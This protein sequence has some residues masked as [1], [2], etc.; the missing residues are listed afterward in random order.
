M[1][2]HRCRCFPF[3][4]TAEFPG[5]GFHSGARVPRYEHVFGNLLDPIELRQLGRRHIL[6]YVRLFRGVWKKLD[7]IVAVVKALVEGRA[8]VRTA[9]GLI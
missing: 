4:V 1:S 8:S 3:S 6:R 2:S 5:C 7:L 9:T